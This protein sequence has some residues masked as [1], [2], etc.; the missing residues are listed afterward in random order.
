VPK[1]PSFFPHTP[2][3]HRIMSIIADLK[4]P[5]SAFLDIGVVQSDSTTKTLGRITINFFPNVPKSATNFGAICNGFPL[6]KPVINRQGEE[7]SSLHYKNI[8]LQRI[9]P[10]FM[11]QGGDLGGYSIYGTT[12]DDENLS[13]SHEPYRIALA[14]SGKNT[15]K[16]QFYFCSGRPNACEHLDGKHVVIGE[17]DFKSQDVIDQIELYGS[18]TGATCARVYIQDCGVLEYFTDEELAS[19]KRFY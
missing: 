8:D 17:T 7:I 16:S 9:I 2:P 1:N 5:K 11:S 19:A 3:H 12:F 6:D 10:N 14:N 18:K 15:N 13:N 4:V